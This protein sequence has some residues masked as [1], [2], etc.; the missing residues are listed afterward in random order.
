MSKELSVDNLFPSEV[1]S[2]TKGN[3]LDVNTLFNNTPLTE[4]EPELTFTSKVLLDRIEKRRAKKLNHYRT[5][6]KYCHTR[7]A[8]ADESQETDIMFTVVDGVSDCKEY[9]S[10]ECLEYVS[11]KLRQDDFDTTILT[12]STMF[13]TWKYLE[14]KK[15]DREES[16]SVSN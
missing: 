16:N 7:I 10:R 5:M 6:L 8:D 3:K 2:G 1:K 15:K 12:D 11:A 4:S 14:L 9:N 13:V